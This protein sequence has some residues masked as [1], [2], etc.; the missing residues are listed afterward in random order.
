MLCTLPFLEKVYKSTASAATTSVLL[1][2]ADPLHKNPRITQL[3]LCTI[4]FLILRIVLLG[5]RTGVYDVSVLQEYDAA[6]LGDW[7]PVAH[8]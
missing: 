4:S 5:S 3:L 8:T 2:T 1:Y 7:L 6:S